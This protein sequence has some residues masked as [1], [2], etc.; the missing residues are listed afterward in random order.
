MKGEGWEVTEGVKISGKAN[1]DS[2]TI[3]RGP[4]EEFLDTELGL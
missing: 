3:N 4:L 2:G 1:W